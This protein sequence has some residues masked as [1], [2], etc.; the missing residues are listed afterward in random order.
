MFA[1]QNEDVQPDI[2]CLGKGLSGGY[3]PISATL[4]SD[5]IY[6]AFLGDYEDKKTLYH[7]HTFA[8]NP[9]AC[10]VSLASLQVFEDEQT[11]DKLQPKIKQLQARMAELE[12]FE[13]VVAPRSRGLVAAFDL[14]VPN[15]K[16]E[17]QVGYDF[18]AKVQKLG[19]RIRPLGNTVI[20]MPP[21]SIESSDIDQ[22][23]DAIKNSL[24]NSAG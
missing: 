21:L 14:I 15:G 11:L 17:S 2:L 12:R 13:Q 4:T 20:I 22:I 23:F 24:E 7:G 5:R 16:N 18:C 1:C 9:L 8:G 19:V 10:A 6:N 3:L